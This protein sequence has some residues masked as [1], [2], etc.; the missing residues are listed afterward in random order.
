MAIE[1]ETQLKP[2]ETSRLTPCGKETVM[3]LIMKFALEEA[4]ASAVEYALL[5][6]FI[7]LVIVGTVTTLGLTLKGVFESVVF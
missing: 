3:Q 2:L 5:S 6:A 1:S 4:G 7:A